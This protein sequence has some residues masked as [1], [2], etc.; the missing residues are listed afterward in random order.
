MGKRAH[1]KRIVE[2]VMDELSTRSG[3]DSLLDEL[4]SD[5]YDGLCAELEYIIR[6]D[7][8]ADD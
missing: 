2:S 6:R 1:A 7:H 8:L 5:I 4:D 3:F